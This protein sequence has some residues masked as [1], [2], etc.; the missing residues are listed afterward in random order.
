MSLTSLLFKHNLL[1]R[2]CS[3]LSGRFGALSSS[4]RHCHAPLLIIATAVEMV[5][6]TLFL[7]VLLTD[8]LPWPVDAAVGRSSLESLHTRITSDW[9]NV[10][11]V[12]KTVG[13]GM[14]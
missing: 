7:E 13:G 6:S 2:G 4:P 12:V 3:V 5:S 11:R 10:S 9:K 1:S 14:S 8:D